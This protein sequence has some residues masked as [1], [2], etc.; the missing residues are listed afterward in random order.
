MTQLTES[1]KNRIVR[2]I[3]RDGMYLADRRGWGLGEVR[4]N[5]NVDA[6]DTLMDYNDCGGNDNFDNFGCVC[7][8]PARTEHMK[9][10]RRIA[11]DAYEMACDLEDRGIRTF[12]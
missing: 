12:N 10:A 9:A 6:L 4:F 1:T 5:M 7:P 3:A 11:G 8:E 2:D